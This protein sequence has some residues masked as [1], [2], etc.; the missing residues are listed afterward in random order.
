MAFEV[1]G[2]GPLVAYRNYVIF[3][4][5][6]RRGHSESVAICVIPWELSAASHS[7]SL[8]CGGGSSVAVLRSHVV[9]GCGVATCTSLTW[10]TC[11]L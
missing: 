5:L 2:V 6:H 11:L 8:S 4:I 9:L 1:C 10:W 3:L 7:D